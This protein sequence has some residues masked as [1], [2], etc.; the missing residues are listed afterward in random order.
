MKT[1]QRTMLSRQLIRNALLAILYEKKL[2][3]VTVK[4]LCERAQV[5]R[6]TFY[7]YYGSPFEVMDEIEWILIRDMEKNIE[8]IIVSKN[9]TA[10][11]LL[12][13][14][15]IMVKRESET[16]LPVLN[17]QDN[18]YI[19]KLLSLPQ[20]ESN[21]KL[22]MEKSYVSSSY[23]YM[24]H[25]IFPAFVNVVRFWLGKEDPESPDE[26]IKIL[27]DLLLSIINSMPLSND[28]F[29]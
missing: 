15:L 24:I 22:I 17:E 26:L 9:P 19:D 7:K 1:D 3:N 8:E 23:E 2:C 5:N 29:S 18:H 12:K 10:R 21:L 20:I 25:F 28:S 14:C 13:R 27:S 6:V 16:I 4:E 11:E